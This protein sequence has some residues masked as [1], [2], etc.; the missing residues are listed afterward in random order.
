M[1][2]C[3]RVAPPDF[4]LQRWSARPARR[5]GVRPWWLAHRVAF[6]CLLRSGRAT[7]D[8]EFW[9]E[10]L[11]HLAALVERDAA[12]NNGAA[13]AFGARG[14]D[15]Q[16]LAFDAQRVAGADRLGPQQF[17]AGAD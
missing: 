2:R 8:D 9:G 12:D 17:A 11:H 1:T 7:R 14:C 5:S 16:Y 4:P 13:V 10:A 6:C 3:R 15:L